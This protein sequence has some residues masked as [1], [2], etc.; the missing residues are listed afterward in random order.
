M[1]FVA[2]LLMIAFMI[3]PSSQKVD[4][5]FFGHRKINELAIY[6]LPPELGK[7]Y[8]SQAN[9]IIELAT[10]PDQRRYV[11]PEEGAKHYIDLDL[12]DS[13]SLP[14]YWN[15]AVDTY[16]EELLRSRG[17]VPWNTYLVYHQLVKAMSEH[18]YERIVRL[19]ADL[20]HY[21]GDAHV[22]LHTTSNY[23]GQETGQ[24]GIHAFWE[25]RLPELYFDS[26]DLFVGRATYVE[27]VQAELWETVMESHAVVDSVLNL[28]ASITRKVGE[29]K[30]Y[31]Y[32]VKG[33]RTVRAPS[34]Y[35]CKEYNEKGGGLVEQRMRSAILRVGSL[36]LSAWI[37]AG[38]PNLNANGE[39]VLQESDSIKTEKVNPGLRSHDY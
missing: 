27:D 23:N 36:W 28:E 14:K 10:A 34:E 12:Y 33:K 22:P 3:L 25:S 4:W 21:V 16:G 35:F 37:D 15:Q 26:Y 8:K 19:S 5:G 39:V 38:Q 11:I 6:T 20:G 7:F 17:I 32:I 24:L 18:N 30:K 31:A 2:Y 13:L 29:D 1:H 9:K